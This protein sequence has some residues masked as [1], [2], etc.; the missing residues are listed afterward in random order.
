[1]PYFNCPKLP[2]MAQSPWTAGTLN[3]LQS[4]KSSTGADEARAKFAH[5]NSDPPP[6][7]DDVARAMRKRALAEGFAWAKLHLGWIV[8]PKNLPRIVQGRLPVPTAGI[9]LSPARLG[10]EDVYILPGG[11][12]AGT[13]IGS[14]YI[15]PDGSPNPLVKSNRG[16]GSASGKHAAISDAERL[17]LLREMIVERDRLRAWINGERVGIETQLRHLDEATQSGLF[18]PETQEGEPTGP[19]NEQATLRQAG[20]K[21]A[22]YRTREKQKLQNWERNERARIERIREAQVSDEARVRALQGQL[23]ALRQRR[24]PQGLPYGQCRVHQ[25]FQQQ[26]RG[27]AEALNSQ[28][29]EAM[30]S[31][32]QNRT[33]ADRMAAELPAEF[34][35]QEQRIDMGARNIE[36]QE[37]YERQLRQDRREVRQTLEEMDRAAN[38]RLRSFNESARQLKELEAEIETLQRLQSNTDG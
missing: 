36:R 18:N 27:D 11:R 14:Q 29:R 31:L 33:E 28:I 23:D 21:S 13:R 38:E 30:A 7:S 16:G 32:A 35:L 24:C 19:P 22:D 8:S 34:R 9:M 37:A 2:I 6:N 26:F 15:M 17:A 1:M 3:P 5:E 12:P 20:S 4:G 25:D 10:T